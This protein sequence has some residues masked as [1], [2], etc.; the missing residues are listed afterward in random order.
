[1]KKLKFMEEEVKNV[2]AGMKN[3]KQPGP[4]G[5]KAEIYK[6]LAKNET[7][8]KSL[9]N[10][11]NKVYET[12]EI[13]ESWKESK[14]VMIAKN[15]K[16]KTKDH[17][18]LA[19]TNISYKIYMSLIRK[20]IIEHL[21]N[22]ELINEYQIGFTKGKRIEESMFILNRCIENTYRKKD[23]LKEP[24]SLIYNIS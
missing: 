19:L 9:T 6:E 13:P 3:K 17:R 7:C 2:V 22:N 11:L 21:Q 1:M 10:A 5:I 16:P 24:L 18:P 4:D 14:T 23:K 8:L 12:N 15:S 20:C